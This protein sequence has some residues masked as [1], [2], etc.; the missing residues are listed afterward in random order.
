MNTLNKVRSKV[1]TIGNRLHIK[2]ATLNDMNVINNT[3]VCTNINTNID[4]NMH[5]NTNTIHKQKQ[6]ETK[7]NNINPLTPF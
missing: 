7:R 5:T 3:N 4:T 2:G 1:M 6:N